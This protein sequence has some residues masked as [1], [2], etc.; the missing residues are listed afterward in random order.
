MATEIRCDMNAGME[1]IFTFRKNNLPFDLSRN[2]RLAVFFDVLNPHTIL[3]QRYLRVIER[4]TGIQKLN[5]RLNNFAG[6]KPVGGHIG[7]HEPTRRPNP[8]MN[9]PVDVDVER[10]F[11]A[12]INLSADPAIEVYLRIDPHNDQDDSRRYLSFK[13]TAIAVLDDDPNDDVDLNGDGGKKPLG[14][15]S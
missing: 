14:G 2:A 10:V 4:T 7:Q 11:F 15:G 12:E 8:K 9:Y 6:V 3:E 5:V 1:R 13:R